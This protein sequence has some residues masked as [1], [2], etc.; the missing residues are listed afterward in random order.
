MKAVSSA[1]WL[2]RAMS[3]HPSRRAIWREAA[4]SRHWASARLRLP[5]EDLRPI[6][7]HVL[8]HRQV[9]PEPMQPNL[10]GRPSL[11]TSYLTP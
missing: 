2:C 6:S 1:H 4:R 3:G 8:N 9:G 11:A 7:D 5:E 10:L